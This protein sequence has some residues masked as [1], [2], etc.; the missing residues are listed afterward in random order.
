MRYE[1]SGDAAAR[2]PCLAPRRRAELGNPGIT[3]DSEASHAKGQSW[4]ISTDAAASLHLLPGARLSA[5]GRRLS[6]GCSWLRPLP[7]LSTVGYGRASRKHPRATNQEHA[8][9]VI[10]GILT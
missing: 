8:F 1:P 3:S 6:A 5:E 10:T 9:H 2:A 7:V 4:P